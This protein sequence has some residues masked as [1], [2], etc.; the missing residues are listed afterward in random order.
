MRAMIEKA[1]ATPKNPEES[2][3]Q[4]EAKWVPPVVAG[5]VVTCMVGSV[6][7]GVS[8][9]PEAFDADNPN[10]P[11]SAENNTRHL[12]MPTEE[13]SSTAANEP[14][15]FVVPRPEQRI[16]PNTTVR[17]TGTEGYGLNAREE[18]GTQATVTEV[19]P[20]GTLLK[21]VELAGE[22]DGYHWALVENQADG[23]I[24]YV[25]IDWLEVVD[26]IQ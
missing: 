19:W 17:V 7:F 26:T 3:P 14:A 22:K 10:N 11:H 2:K 25:V 12:N 24:A 5:A 6:I 8:R 21:V 15:E 23:T 13:V 16:L 4:K 18:V 9:N 1:M 20:D